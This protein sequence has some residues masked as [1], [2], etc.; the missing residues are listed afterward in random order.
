MHKVNA[1][2]VSFVQS[3]SP[4][5][6][7]TLDMDATLV[8]THKQQACYSCQK[9]RASQ[10]LT[11]YWAEKVDNASSEFRDGNVPA[12]YQSA[13]S[14]DRSTWGICLRSVDRVC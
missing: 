9:Y 13:A 3:R 5:R 6:E 10:P 11:T 7:A 2:L 12:R 8:E 14:V 4:S 1:E